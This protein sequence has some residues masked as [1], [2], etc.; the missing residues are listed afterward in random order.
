[1]VLSKDEE[2]HP[3]DRLRS[4][5]KEKIYF[6]RVVDLAV[7]S[8]FLNPDPNSEVGHFAFSPRYYE[9]REFEARLAREI[10]DFE[11]E[12]PELASRIKSRR[13][14]AFNIS[15]Q[16]QENWTEKEQARHLILVGASYRIWPTGVSHV[17]TYP[18]DDNGHGR[19]VT[20]RSDLTEFNKRRVIRILRDAGKLRNPDLFK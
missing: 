18:W 13:L 6:K 8:G 11:T 17:L 5:E 9:G 2:I 15:E 16:E 20:F 14:A 12:R 7:W 1:V 4:E 3:L 19:P 10:I